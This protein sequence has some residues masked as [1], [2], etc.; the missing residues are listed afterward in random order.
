MM[1]AMNSNAIRTFVGRS[2][3]AVAY[4]A[5][6]FE[7]LWLVIIGL[8]PLIETGV[9]DTL[10]NPPQPIARQDERQE[11]M[12]PVVIAAVGAMTVVILGVTVVI[13]IKLPATIL[14]SGDVV[15]ER[16]AAKTLPVITHHKPLPAKKRRELSRRLRLVFE[17]VACAIPLVIL[18][19]LPTPDELT[20]AVVMGVGIFL[21][22]LAFLGFTSGWLIE[23][24]PA[25]SRTRSHASR[26]S[27]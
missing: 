2:L 23:P 1:K 24:K 13:L 7:W 8:P 19:F 15:M 5:L 26:G 4:L 25:T 10:V 9:F 6:V 14:K 21:G 12:S 20:Q 27:R 17:L 18:P 22:G 3:M 16:A 11:D